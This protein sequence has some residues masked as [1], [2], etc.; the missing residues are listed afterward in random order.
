MTNTLTK[1]ILAVVFVALVGFNSFF[2][3]GNQE[4]STTRDSPVSLERMNSYAPI[5]QTDDDENEEQDEDLSTEELQTINGRLTE[6]QAK[7][8]AL[9]TIGS[10][11]VID[12]EAE[13]E[14]G[15]L[16]YGITI[17]SQGD[18]VEVEVDGLTGDVLEIE[19]G[20]DDKGEKED[21]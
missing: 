5:Q 14:N 6:A 7:A 9:E 2:I 19:W 20:D 10:G 3:L 17:L 21:D 13:R 4:K 15:R 12:F 16:L 11:T 18:T 1:I 8:I